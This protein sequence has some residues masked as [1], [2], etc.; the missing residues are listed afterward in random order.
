MKF[1][2][3]ILLL[4]GIIAGPGYFLYCAI[5]SGSQLDRVNVFSQDVNSVSVGS[6]T[7]QSSGANAHWSTPVPLELTPEMNPMSVKAVVR[8]MPPAGAARKRAG[9]RAALVKDGLS[10]WEKTFSVTAKK[11]KKEEGTVKI[12]AGPLPK[13]TVAVKTFSIEESGTYLL[14]VQRE[15]EHELAVAVL[16]MDIRRNVIIPNTVVVAS[17]GGS[18]LLGMVGLI[19]LGKKRKQT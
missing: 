2:S 11:E 9:Y 5:L 15:G 1:I 4:L 6:V 18:L 7:V 19:A 10:V 3:T 8:Y 16:D 12:G 17:G 14:D 13:V